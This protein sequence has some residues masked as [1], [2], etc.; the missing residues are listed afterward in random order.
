[1]TT[2]GKRTMSPGLAKYLDSLKFGFYTCFRPLDG[3]W[4]L[5]HEKRGTMAAANTFV[6]ISSI[7]Q[8]VWLLSSNFQF[9]NMNPEWFSSFWVLVYFVVPM[10][11]FC[12]ANWCLTTLFD[13]KG[14]ISDI[15]MVWAYAMVPQTILRLISIPVGHILT[16]EEGMIHVLITTG[17]TTWF[18]LLL[19]LG[20]KQV[21]DYSLSKALLTTI[22]SLMAMGI[23]IFIFLMFFAVVSDGIAYFYAL[24]QEFMFRVRR[25]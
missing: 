22:L 8:I 18:Y 24:A 25:G 21:H 7:A 19:I 9:I 20:V 14:R 5:V 16:Y 12:V 15:Y 17:A 3:F 10:F 23:M 1:M 11:L 4:D 6:I 13:G 2:A